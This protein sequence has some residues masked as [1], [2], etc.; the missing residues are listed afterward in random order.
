M[1]SL[2]STSSEGIWILFVG[3]IFVANYAVAKILQFAVSPPHLEI[4]Q[5]F[6]VRA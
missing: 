3:H 6:L 1:L 4:C 5:I 2:P